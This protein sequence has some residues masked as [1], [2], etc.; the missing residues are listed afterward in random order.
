VFKTYLRRNRSKHVVLYNKRNL[1]VFGRILTYF[2]YKQHNG[3]TSLKK[4]SK[5]KIELKVPVRPA[6]RAAQKAKLYFIASPTTCLVELGD[7]L[8]VKST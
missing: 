2:C 8:A 5:F 7:L 1:V 3:M 6:L 4:Y